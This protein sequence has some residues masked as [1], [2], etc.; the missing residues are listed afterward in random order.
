MRCFMNRTI[1]V[2]DDEP[3]MVDMIR[4]YLEKE[5]FTVKTA[6]NGRQALLL[7]QNEKPDLVILDWMM[8]DISGMDIL[9]EI[10]KKSMVPVIMLTAKA[11]EVDKLLGLEFGADDYITKP[12]SLRELVARIRIP[13]RRID[14]QS[15]ERTD[16]LQIGQLLIDLKR[17]EVLVKHKAVNNLTPTEFKILTVL[18]ESPGRV[19]SRLQL[20]EGALGEAYEGYER[21]LDTHIS[22]LR[23]KIE[24]NP[25]DPQY[26]ITVYGIG[27]K[28][29]KGDNG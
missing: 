27:Y 29:G 2:V 23:K 11:E 25:S 28:M 20:M 12:F 6:N 17:H 13:L 5:N 19:F 22:N 15:V 16:K 14:S 7:F 10:R 1:L 21:S 8:P 3:K 4:I 9:K 26:V 18:A 24:D